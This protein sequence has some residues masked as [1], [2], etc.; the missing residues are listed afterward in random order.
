[1]ELVIPEDIKRVKIDVGLSYSAP[2]SEAWLSREKDLFVIAFE[3]DP[4]NLKS[5]KSD[6]IAKRASNH[7]AP[8]QE[9]NKDRIKI[10]ECA[11]GE[12]EPGTTLP[13]YS[14]NKDSGCS[15]IHKPVSSFAR[16]QN[17][18]KQMS[19]VAYPLSH[20]LKDFPWD[21]FPHIEYLKVDAQGLDLSVLK[22]CGSY[23]QR[24]VYVTAEADG[25]CYEGAGDCN[26][27]NITSY[28]RGQGFDEVKH[29]NTK[30]PTFLNR[31]LKHLSHVFIQQS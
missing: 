30:D 7:G 10:Y 21:R 11:L 28:M 2:Q 4:G 15:S 20:F 31:K 5:L 22:S 9:C 24:F 25:H 23:I 19:V 27:A 18:Y 12:Y 6:P 1:M 8:L 3:P 29:R 16:L 17:G 14:T 26:K 13:W